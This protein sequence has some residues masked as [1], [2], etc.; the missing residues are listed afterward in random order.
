MSKVAG[1]A[2]LKKQPLVL[3]ILIMSLSACQ[4]LS[5]RQQSTMLEDTLRRY[6]ATV[7]WGNIQ[8]AQQFQAD[9]AAEQPLL[10]PDLRI[11]RY[12][13]VQGPV[14]IE[15]QR[16]VQTVSIEYV[17]ESTQTVRQLFDQ[18]V[19]QYDTDAESWARQNPIPEFR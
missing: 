11:T 12:E 10:P 5:E 2:R 6:E 3:L 16:A 7:R 13:V 1:E 15:G 8:L 17:F 4:T 18:Q 9:Q 14:L 19:W